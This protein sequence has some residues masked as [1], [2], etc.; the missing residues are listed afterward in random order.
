MVFFPDAFI[1][2]VIGR[3]S[4]VIFCFLLVE[5]FLHTKNV[6]LYLKRLAIWA[7]ISEVPFDLAFSGRLFDPNS[8]NVFFT[9]LSGILAIHVISLGLSAF[10]KIL[11]VLMIVLVSSL[12][13]FDYNYLGILQVIAFYLFRNHLK[14]V[15]FSAVGILNT[16]FWGRIF[17]QGWALL[18]FLP[19]SQYNGLQGRKTG[20]IF[21]SFYAV[22]LTIIGILRVFI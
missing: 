13:H 12:L 8:Q 11:L 3:M 17:F 19:I 22:H 21:Y 6:N 5:G 1:L 9:L 18:A 7:L 14:W 16:F 4:F 10:K 15:K 2:R 20:R